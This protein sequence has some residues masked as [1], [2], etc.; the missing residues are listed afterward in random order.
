LTKY[1]SGVSRS[2]FGVLDGMR[3]RQQEQMQ[4]STRTTH[5]SAKR[6]RLD[7]SAA[8]QMIQSLDR[9]EV[10]QDAIKRCLTEAIDANNPDLDAAASKD[11]EL[12]AASTASVPLYIIPLSNLDDPSHDIQTP[13]FTFRP[14]LPFQSI[15]LRLD[16]KKA[17]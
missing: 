6:L 3:K 2:L 12:V 16:V 5:A 14:I 7:S 15:A 8:S 4:E 10:T 9:K 1:V 11:V 13:L 17:L